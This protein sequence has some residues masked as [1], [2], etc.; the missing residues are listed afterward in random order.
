VRGFREEEVQWEAEAG[1]QEL[2][3]LSRWSLE[4]VFV[5][6]RAAET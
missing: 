4:E 6:E 1:P 2:L 3:L 5:E